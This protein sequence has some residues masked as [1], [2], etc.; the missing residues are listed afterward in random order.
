MA[1]VYEPPLQ[2]HYLKRP[3]VLEPLTASQLPEVRYYDSQGKPLPSDAKEDLID[4]SE[5]LIRIKPGILYQP[6]PAF[7]KNDQGEYRY[8]NLSIKEASHYRVFADFKEV[9]TRELIAE[10][11]VYQIKRLADP[12]V[13]SPIFGL[14]SR[15]I[16]G[17]Q[18][19]RD[20]LKQNKLISNETDL[21][22]Y[23][24]QG[25]ELVDR[26]TYK[27]ILKGKYPQFRFWLAMA[28]FAPMPWEAVQFY[29]QPGFMAHNI[30]LDWYPVGTGPYMLVENNPNRRM[31]LLRNPNYHFDTYP[32]EGSESDEEKGLLVDRGKQLPFVDKAIFS[33]ER[34]QIPYWNK[35]LQGY[36][37]LS[38]ISPDNFTSAISFSPEGNA[39]LTENLQKKGIRLRTAIS[40]DMWYWGF[41][42]LDETVGGNSERARKLRQAIRMA[43]DI[44]EYIHIFTNGRGIPARG[45][46]PP[47]VFGFEVQPPLKAKNLID[48]KKLLQE[49]GYTKDI[50]LYM[51]SIMGGDPDEI[52]LFAWM[53]D[54]FAKLNIQLIIRGSDYNRFQDKLKQGTTQIF[55]FGWSSDYPDPENFLFLLY[56]PNGSAQF[57]GENTVNYSNPEFDKLFEKMRVMPDG[58]ERL[59]L[60][61]RMIE[62]LHRDSPWIFGFS[63]KSFILSQEWMRIGKQSN[64]INNTLKYAK[65]NPVLRAKDRSEWNKP[66]LW[67][68]WGLIILALM[69]TG[70][71]IFRLW[72]KQYLTRQDT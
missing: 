23:Q 70:L 3:Y 33:L 41:N 63:T 59:S 38:G 15:Y 34:E 19:L 49:A 55:F 6:H 50:T 29:A 56:G 54:Q 11:Y 65:V 31:V 72:Q 30:S 52:T 60:I 42:M 71:I 62:I 24:L 39:R 13:S 18:T 53:K 14:M 32:N 9:G 35:F 37:D 25:V 66:L 46:L 2:Y 17:L 27:I 16:I 45:P 48:A 68:L 12:A 28:F 51:D 40:N 36:Y 21:R 61:R 67:P 8:L 26:Y 22:N 47:E 58:A 20:T 5:Y 1:Q 10:D 43:F 69:L 64:L 4:R 57:G 44:E 7:A